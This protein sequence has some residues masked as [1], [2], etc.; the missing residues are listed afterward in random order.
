[1]PRAQSDTT[2]TAATKAKKTP[3]R[4]TTTR[5]KAA[6]ASPTKRATTRS[7][8]PKVAVENESTSSS[9]P[10]TIRR[11]PTPLAETTRRQRKQRIILG[12]ATVISAVCFG[13]GVY[14]GMSE[15]GAIDVTTIIQ[16]G[17]EQ[18]SRGEYVDSR[19]GQTVTRTVSTQSGIGRTNSGLRASAPSETAPADTPAE[20][21]ESV[22]N[23]TSTATSSS[24]STTEATAT[25]STTAATTTTDTII[26][27]V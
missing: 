18:I 22:D 12:I 14:I 24:A 6:T 3:T 10:P 13:A 15:D 7:R 9:T 8:A 11:A 1:M 20:P 4:R 27:D 5:T 2:T 25:S 26:D 17:N 21:I 23:A 16:A 19:T